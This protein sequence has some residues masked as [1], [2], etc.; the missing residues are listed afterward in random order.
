MLCRLLVVVVVVVYGTFSD[1][2]GGGGRR[3]RGQTQKHYV[4]CPT[5]M[6]V[7]PNVLNMM[8]GGS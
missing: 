7:M 8:D 6:I 5:P 2:Q 4:N 1:G 3:R